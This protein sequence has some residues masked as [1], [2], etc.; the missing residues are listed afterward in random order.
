MPS[1][2]ITP[3]LI[4]K[5]TLSACAV[6]GHAL[7]SMRPAGPRPATRRNLVR[8]RY[9]AAALGALALLGIA[10]GSASAARGLD[11]GIG[12][13]LFLDFRSS[14][15]GQWLQRAEEAH[16]RMIRLGANWRSIAGSAPPA[17]PTDPADPSYDWGVL[18]TAVRD[19]AARGFDVMLLLNK[20][21]RWAEGPNRPRGAQ[22]G[23]WKPD[24][25]AFGKFGQAIAQRYSGNYPDPAGPGTLPRVGYYEAWN[26]PNLDFWLAPQ[27][28]GGKNTGPELY[29]A[30]HNAFAEGVKS[31]Q[32]DDKIVGPALAPFGGITE[33]RRTRTRPMQFLRA[34]FCLKGRQKLKPVPCPKG[35]RVNLDIFSHHPITVT[36]PPNQKAFHPDDATAGDM[37]KVKRTLRAAERGG[38]ILPAGRRPMW[39]TEYWYRSDPPAE[40]GVPLKR[41]ARWIQQSLYLF[42]KQGVKLAIYNLIRDR[43]VFD[44]ETAFGLYFRN[45]DAKPAA[46]AFAFPLVANRKSKSK[47]LVWGKSPATGK[48]RVQ[49][50]KGKGWKTVARLSATEGK[51]FKK[52]L[53]LR[54][55]E[56]L[57]AKVSGEKSL[58]WSQ[59]R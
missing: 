54:G 56:K 12:D 33:Q 40:G 32:P 3:I 51:V 57:R 18:D 29:R 43:P 21:P 5:S 14:V 49:R 30:L 39:V 13:E 10:P 38:T 26:E 45:G 36:G 47:L 28:S 46:T 35:G 58:V 24:P 27:Y 16:V 8:V 42:W 17:A 4:L 53:R 31:V 37:R 11:T 48:L 1:H 59:K 52:V 22:A 7:K 23:S 50:R 15:R 34:L 2:A 9:A 20:A 41:H 44:P 55:K 19:A 6:A 25:V